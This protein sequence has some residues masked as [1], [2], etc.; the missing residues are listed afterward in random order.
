MNAPVFGPA[1]VDYIMH[2]WSGCRDC[3]DENG[4]CP[5]S[6][7]PCPTEEARRVVVKVLDALAYG[8][9]HGYIPAPAGGAADLILIDDPL[10][11]GD[12]VATPEQKAWIGTVVESRVLRSPETDD[13]TR[14]TYGP[15]TPNEGGDDNGIVARLRDYALC[16]DGDIDEA[17]DMLEFLLRGKSEEE[18][19]ASMRAAASHVLSCTCP[20]DLSYVCDFCIGRGGRSIKD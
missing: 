5:I 3:A 15:G 11:P 4:T 8:L 2:Y 14:P 12:I 17:A 20:A 7:L 18:V 16:H 10:K 6:L 9:S 19:K 1:C 13:A